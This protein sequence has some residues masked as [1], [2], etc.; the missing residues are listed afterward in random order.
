MDDKN[1]R[2][3]IPLPKALPVELCRLLFLYIL[4]LFTSC[5]RDIDYIRP[6]DIQ[7]LEAKTYIWKA[8]NLWYYWQSRVP[9]LADGAIDD[10]EKEADRFKGKTKKELFQSLLLH[11]D[12]RFSVAYE[13]YEDLLDWLHDVSVSSGMRYGLIRMGKDSNRL[14]GYVRYV[15]HGSPAEKAGIKRGDIIVKVDDRAITLDN[16]KSLWIAPTTL[17]LTFATQQGD[18]LV[19]TKIKTVTKQKIKEDPILLYEI[20]NGTIGYLVYNGFQSGSEGDLNRIFGGFKSRGITDL[21]LDLRYN[22]GGSLSTATYLASMIDGTESGKIF[23]EIRFNEKLGWVQ[24]REFA[25][26][27]NSKP[28]NS[29]TGLS[30][31][32][33]L[34]SRLTASASEAVINGLK[35]FWGTR[36]Q[37]IGAQT[38][39]K[40]EGSIT[41]VNKPTNSYLLPAKTRDMPS[42]K[43]AMQLIAS[44]V[45]NSDGSP[46][47]RDGLSPDFEIDEIS[48]LKGM[49]PLGD[50]QEQL[51]RAALDLIAGKSPA[52]PINSDNRFFGTAVYSNIMEKGTFGQTLIDE[53]MD[54]EP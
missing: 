19:E 9:A 27:F 11:P 34:T 31:L 36:L 32:V 16:Y 29:L 3:T 4:V 13:N 48:G 20:I 43:F 35:P 22:G 8:M 28:I 47:P 26:E 46:V 45:F 40:S 53:Q 7:N 25:T 21:V 54:F 2:L 33:V 24:K 1:H 15:V 23:Q 41:L 14:I 37:L 39:G 49:K 51:L 6:A 18:K 52:L 42:E 17:E 10:P 38:R 44:R 50:P 12:D 30:H 5:K